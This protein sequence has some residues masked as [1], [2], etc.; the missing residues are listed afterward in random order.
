MRHEATGFGQSAH[1]LDEPGLAD[2]RLAAHVD[3][4]TASPCDRRGQHAFELFDLGHA[5]DEWAARGRRCFGWPRQPP[6]T[7]RSGETL[8]LG[9]AERL[10]K[11]AVGDGAMDAFRKQRL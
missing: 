2:S 9:L 4:V 5:T 11:A 8:D 7:H 6:N 3:G 1:L 10:A